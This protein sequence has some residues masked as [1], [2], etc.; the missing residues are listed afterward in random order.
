MLDVVCADKCRV[1]PLAVPVFADIDAEDF[2]V[3]PEAVKFRVTKHT[4][5]ASCPVR[6]RVKIWR[7]VWAVS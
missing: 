1:V 2:N 5:P 4:K 6:I 7:R 3:D